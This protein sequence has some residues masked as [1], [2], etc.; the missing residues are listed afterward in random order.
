MIRVLARYNLLHDNKLEVSVDFAAI[1]QL[2]KMCRFGLARRLQHRI[3]HV[4]PVEVQVADLELRR[5]LL[6][7]RFAQ[8][9]EGLDAKV[10]VAIGG[11]RKNFRGGTFS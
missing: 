10:S 5:E 9:L 1:Y 3:V 2:T 7:V 11:V 4:Q 6:S 8:H